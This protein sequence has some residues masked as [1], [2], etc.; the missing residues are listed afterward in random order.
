MGFLTTQDGRS[1]SPHHSWI[2]VALAGSVRLRD[3]AGNNV[4]TSPCH[5]FRS[6]MWPPHFAFNARVDGGVN[7]IAAAGI[8]VEPSD[9]GLGNDGVVLIPDDHLGPAFNRVVLCITAA[10][11]LIRS[12]L[13]PPLED[14]F[15]FLIGETG[16]GGI[17]VLCICFHA[18]QAHQNHR[19]PGWNHEPLAN[20]VIF[21]MSHGLIIGWIWALP[22]TSP[23]QPPQPQRG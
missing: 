3:D 5:S 21:S 11:A 8:K 15:D 18:G 4:E 10:N 9:T 7:V 19:K 2:R 20:R 16:T 23:W 14:R 13:L 1:I 17:F 22:V 12:Q 6:W